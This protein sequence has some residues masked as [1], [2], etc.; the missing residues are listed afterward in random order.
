VRVGG[1]FLFW[2]SRCI[3]VWFL[4]RPIIRVTFTRQ[5][6]QVPVGSGGRV[7]RDV[8]VFQDLG[9]QL[10]LEVGSTGVIEFILFDEDDILGGRISRIGVVMHDQHGQRFPR[11]GI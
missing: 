6:G 1:W 2:I 8:V 3:V 7:E 4:G 11:Q 9:G 5:G 10:D